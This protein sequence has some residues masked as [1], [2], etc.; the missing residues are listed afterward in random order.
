MLADEVSEG[1]TMIVEQPYILHEIVDDRI[2]IITLNRPSKRNALS[3]AL[4]AQLRDALDG[5]KKSKVRVVILRAT[6][7]TKVW[8][9]GHDVAELPQE[10]FDPLG[11]DDPLEMTLRAVQKYP[12]PVIAQVTG[13]V[14]GGACDLAMTCDI[15]IGDPSCSFCM[16]PARLGVPY[17]SSGLIHFLGRVSL[18]IAK[19]MFFTASPVEAERAAQLGL[20]NHLVPAEELEP[21]ALAM[22]RRIASLSSAAIEVI[23]EQFRALTMSR[24]LPAETF[25]RINALRAAVYNS[26]D[27]AEAIQAFLEKR[28]PKFTEA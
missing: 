8:S 28:E 16:T 13:A 12:G 11:Y 23:K 9:A 24:P 21:F 25:E 1:G 22:A 4:L 3:K 15:A 6:P 18:N 17:N 27:Y 10:H 5:F 14:W 26:A 7:G 20:I 19:E 2:G